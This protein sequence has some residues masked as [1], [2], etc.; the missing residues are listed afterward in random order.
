MTESIQE[1]QDQRFEAQKKSLTLLCNDVKKDLKSVCSSFKKRLREYKHYKNKVDAL[2]EVVKTNRGEALNDLTWDDGSPIPTSDAFFSILVNPAPVANKQVEQPLTSSKDYKGKR[3]CGG[4]FKPFVFREE[5]NGAA[6]GK[7]EGSETAGKKFH[8]NSLYEL[9]PS[10]EWTVVIDETGTF[11]NKEGSEDGSNDKIVGVFIP[12]NVEL[13]PLCFHGCEN[14]SFSKLEAPIRYLLDS[15]CGIL[16]FTVEALGS[17]PK[18]PWLTAIKEL[19][20]LAAYILPY[21]RRQEVKLNVVVERRGVFDDKTDLKVMQSWVSDDIASCYFKL[22]PSR[23]KISFLVEDK[24]YDLNGY[25][26]AVAYLWGTKKEELQYLR[27]YTCWEGT[28]LLGKGAWTL[29]DFH[30]K[31]G[32]G[33]FVS[34]DDWIELVD[35][36]PYEQSLV[37]LFLERYGSQSVASEHWDEYLFALNAVVAKND[38]A[39]LVFKGVRLLEKYLSNVDENTKRIKSYMLWALCKLAESQIQSAYSNSLDLFKEFTDVCKRLNK[40]F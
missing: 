21:D 10:Q 37:G 16:G 31:V 19:L 29:D 11:Q 3:Y 25:A 20:I 23:L 33:K 35:M 13:K 28:C 27:D 30:D 38:S 5:E 34:A 17:E 9:R 18:E 14:N 24:S 4:N 39:P 12:E 2:Y 7:S 32:R 15:R 6:D 1:D 26:D 40:N 8:P 36:C 22:A